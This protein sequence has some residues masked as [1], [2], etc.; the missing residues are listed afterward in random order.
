[1][2]NDISTVQTKPNLVPVFGLFTANAISAIGNRMT[3]IAIP[4][5]VLQTTGS[6]AKTGLV[7]FFIILP[8]IFSAV[9]TGPLVDKLGYRV[10]SII[11]DLVC[12]LAIGAIPLLY[13]LGL[14]DFWFLLALVFISNLFE[15]PGA[16]ARIAIL[17]DLAVQ[18]NMSNEKI[19]S[20][21]QA[22]GQG[23]GLL[24]APV[25]GVLIAWIGTSEV[26]WVD[27]LS[28]AISAILVLLLVQGSKTKPV[29]KSEEPQDWWHSVLEGFRFILSDRLFRFLLSAA[30]FINLLETAKFSVILPFYTRTFFG[31]A[32]DLGFL[33]A[34]SGGGLVIGS[35]LYGTFSQKI[36]Q[37]ALVIG[38]LFIMMLQYLALALVPP[39]WVLLIVFAITGIAAGPIN[40][41][42]FAVAF[43][44]V[45][46]DRL[47]RVFGSINAVSQL[48]TPFGVLIAGF[49]LE[50]A[51]LQ[52][53][54]LT[55]GIIFAGVIATFPF[56]RSLRELDS[57][58][59]NKN[60]VQPTE[61]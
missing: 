52:P 44:R 43:K 3:Q 34:V 58:E 54:L 48:M 35:L 60:Q 50:Q 53:V 31:E 17:P 32:V 51:P 22:I 49:I 24:G 39:Y 16:T 15:V 56:S 38:G 13:S 11:S 61:S 33:I 23:A 55:M 6:V 47:G 46:S 57:L 10:S 12:T 1:M 37:R 42:V 8:S 26:L 45:P 4:W 5:F 18:A 30:L 25:G 2:V 9:L 21:E 41:L 27:A 36:S 59:G 7:S 14:L 40:P 29:E 19:S 20:L 28:F